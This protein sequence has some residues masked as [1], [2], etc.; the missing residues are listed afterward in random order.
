MKIIGHRGAKGLAPENT[1]SSI[2]KAVD[3]GIT[4]VEFDLR[5]TQDEVVI[6]HH[7]EALVD[8]HGQAHAIAR[9]KYDDLRAL[10]SDLT[11]YETVLTT[12][13][14]T[15]D[16]LAEVK[17]G[18]PV[19]PIAAIIEKQ[20]KKG[21]QPADFLFCSFDQGVLVELQQAFPEVQLVVNEGWSG[22]RATHRARQLRTQRISMDQRWLWPGF[23]RSLARSGYHLSAYT[24]N[25]PAKA[26]R[27]AKHGLYATITDYPDR[28]RTL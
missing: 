27:W 6:L 7:D 3:C 13:G 18:V 21:W 11:T 5:V 26:R 2:Q 19:A 28:F 23:I 8:A 14:K 24:L 10:K 20:L 9:T 25:N 16:L 22:V 4:E 15:I 12:F 17:P 1:L